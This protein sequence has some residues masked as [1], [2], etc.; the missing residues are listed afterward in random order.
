VSFIP[1]A[2]FPTEQ[3]RRSFLARLASAPGTPGG[4]EAFW[5]DPVA[6][7]KSNL[8]R[9]DVILI[10]DNYAE[11]LQLVSAVLGWP[12]HAMDAKW[13]VAGK[14]DGIAKRSWD[15]V[16][17]SRDIWP[18]EAEVAAAGT[19]AQRAAAESLAAGSPQL[20]LSEGDKS[21][22]FVRPSPA[23]TW[24]EAQGAAFLSVDAALALNAPSL[25]VYEYGKELS[26]VQMRRA[27]LEPS[28]TTKTMGKCCEDDQPQ[29]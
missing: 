24:G 23:G 3:E 2:P 16:G 5:S 29:W 13:N 14:K 8:R 20:E 21:K 28:F 1:P 7:A 17:H 27:G 18:S 9:F 4:V 19:A 15:V 6:T 25:D 26:F 12:A 22:G 10:L 11:T